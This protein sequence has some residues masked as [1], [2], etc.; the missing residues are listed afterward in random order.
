MLIC[1]ATTLRRPTRPAG[2]LRHD[3]TNVLVVD[4][5]ESDLMALIPL[6]MENFRGNRVGP[7]V[8]QQLLAPP[9]ATSNVDGRQPADIARTNWIW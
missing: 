5:G 2:L 3:H 4:I 8:S 9:T 7:L 1:V 6:G